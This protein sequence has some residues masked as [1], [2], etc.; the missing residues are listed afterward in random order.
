M[1]TF[2]CDTLELLPA[3]GNSIDQIYWKRGST[4]TYLI[5]YIWIVASTVYKDKMLGILLTMHPLQRTCY[6]TL[7]LNGELLSGIRQLAGLFPT[8]NLLVFQSFTI[9]FSLTKCM[10][11]KIRKHFQCVQ[12]ICVTY[13]HKHLYTPHIVLLLLYFASVVLSFWGIKT[14]QAE[15]KQNETGNQSFVFFL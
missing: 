7:L 2:C 13:L 8:W 5:L 6:L 1:K 12:Y 15:Q 11:F 10:L 9:Q 3:R 4:Y 14:E